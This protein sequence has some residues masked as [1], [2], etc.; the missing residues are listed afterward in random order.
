MRRRRKS[1][2]A[3]LP[4][5]PTFVGDSSFGRT[6]YDFQDAFS[7]T[8]E[9]GDFVQR[10][11]PLTLDETPEQDTSLT[12]TLSDYVQGQEYVLERVV[13]SVFVKLSQNSDQ[14]VTNIL[15]CGA[16]A[17]LPTQEGA[18]QPDLPPEEWNPFFAQNAQQ[19]W[20][21]RRVWQLQNNEFSGNQFQNA[22]PAS[23]MNYNSVADGPHIDTRGAK[24]RVRKEQRL[25]IVCASVVLGAQ[26]GNTVTSVRWTYDLRMF[27]AMRRASGRSAF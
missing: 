5:N 25:Y 1:G 11:V 22:V 20:I 4:V 9:V 3:W 23:N 2:G 17:I 15:A 24:R 19:P 14:D 8:S 7:G 18:D 13:G 16:L 10:A 6:Y 12:Y 27:G 26:D 21:W